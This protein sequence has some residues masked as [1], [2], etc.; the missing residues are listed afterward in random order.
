MHQDKLEAYGVT[1]LDDLVN[2]NIINDDDLRTEVGLAD[3]E[4]AAFRASAALTKAERAASAAASTAGAR[5]GL[6]GEAGA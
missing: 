3:A 6:A 2:P 5:A 1:T 4:V